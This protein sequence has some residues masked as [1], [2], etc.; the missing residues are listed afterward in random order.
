MRA[1]IILAV[2]ALLLAAPAFAQGASHSVVL[3]W[4]ASTTPGVG[5]VVLRGTQSLAENVTLT[6]APVAVGCSGATCTFTDLGTTANPLVEGTVYFYLV[7]AVN[8]TT[9][10]TSVNS[11][12]VSGMIPIVIVIPSAPGGLKITIQ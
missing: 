1:R 4:T 7:R 2:A 3:T 10:A 9:Q 11:N 6:S 12:E 8:M 5:Y